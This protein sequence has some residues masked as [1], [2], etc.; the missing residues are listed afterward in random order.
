MCPTGRVPFLIDLP[1]RSAT[2]RDCTIPVASAPPHEKQTRAL[3]AI[4]LDSSFKV[5]DQLLPSK[6]SKLHMFVA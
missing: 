5:P 6:R 2:R 4:L 1:M 3:S